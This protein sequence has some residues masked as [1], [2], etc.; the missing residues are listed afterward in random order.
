M[1]SYAMAAA[2]PGNFGVGHG[3]AEAADRAQHKR[4]KALPL[5]CCLQGE[6]LPDA[7]RD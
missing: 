7:G 2:L 3:D 4:A 5:L 1:N 6:L